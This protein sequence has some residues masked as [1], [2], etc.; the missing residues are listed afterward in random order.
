MDVLGRMHSGRVPTGRAASDAGPE[1]QSPTVD[2]GATEW[3]V[4]P[5]RLYLTVAEAFAVEYPR[6]VRLLT[7]YCGDQEVARDLAQEA[8]ARGCLH[9]NQVRSMRDQRAWFTRVAVNLANSRWR[10]LRVERR[11]LHLSG[12]GT[13]PDP[14]GE[15]AQALA[16]RAALAGLTSRQRTAVLLRY[17]EDLDLAATAR[18]MGC[19]TGTVKK[20]TAR[21]LAGLRTH[22]RFELPTEDHGD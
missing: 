3:N 16:V 7:A 5:G 9:W 12:P 21:G 8:L 15:V 17:F 19:S 13:L 22:L 6:L 18:A 11:L 4:T 1:P 2:S 14:A 20:L 10:R